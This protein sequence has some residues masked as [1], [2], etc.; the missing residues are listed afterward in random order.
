MLKKRKFV[1]VAVSKEN[2]KA[3]DYEAQG[4]VVNYDGHLQTITVK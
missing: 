3:F 4:N 1:I 2:P